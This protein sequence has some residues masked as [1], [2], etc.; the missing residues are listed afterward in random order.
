MAKII[1]FNP[2]LRQQDGAVT[3][4]SCDHKD[5]I[6]FTASRT[7]ECAVC[8]AKL[9]P[10]DVMVELLKGSKPPGDNNRELKLYSR[11]L[12]RRHQDKRPKRK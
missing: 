12:E 9:D 1:R 10:F 3:A 11:E 5:V 2:R 6:A 8:G 4:T 7:V